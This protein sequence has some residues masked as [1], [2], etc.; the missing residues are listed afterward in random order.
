MKETTIEKVSKT[1]SGAVQTEVGINWAHYS[2]NA[3]GRLQ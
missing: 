3:K 2:I 1:A